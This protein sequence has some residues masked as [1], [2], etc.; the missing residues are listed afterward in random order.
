MRYRME[1]GTVVDT[2]KAKAKYTSA[3][4]WDGRNNINRPTRDQWTDQTLYRSRK[5]RWYIV[6]TSCWQ[7]ALPYATW[8][9]PEEAAAWLALNDHEIPEELNQAADRSTE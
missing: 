1:D 7:G 5:S 2:D 9:S 8:I 3:S 6:H 4:D